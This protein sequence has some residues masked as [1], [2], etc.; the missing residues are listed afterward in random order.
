VPD[1]DARSIGAKFVTQ[2]I[3][4]GY[5]RTLFVYEFV[6]ELLEKAGF[7]RIERSAYKQTSSP[8][9]DIVEIDNRELESLFVEAF[10]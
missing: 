10:K 3:W 7:T 6:E 9:A 1:E 4:Y 2:M 8:F 5:S